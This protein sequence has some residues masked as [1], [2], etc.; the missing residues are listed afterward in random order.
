M[1]DN[2]D[3]YVLQIYY[4]LYDYTL[5]EKAD[6]IPYITGIESVTDYIWTDEF[7]EGFQYVISD[8]P[9]DYLTTYLTALTSVYGYTMTSENVYQNT[10]TG[11]QIEVKEDS[12]YQQFY[13]TLI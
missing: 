10:E 11:L 9:E 3:S 4:D 1:K 8:A 6:Y 2:E 5:G 13:I 7:P 12:G